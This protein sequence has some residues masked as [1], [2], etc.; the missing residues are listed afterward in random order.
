MMQCFKPILNAVQNGSHPKAPAEG[1]FDPTSVMALFF[2]DQ[3][4]LRLL[5]IQ[6][7]D[8]QGYTWANQMAFPGGH[9]EKTD[10]DSE[11]AALREMEEET[12]ILRKDV[13]VIGSVGHFQTLNNKDI[14][15]WTG[16]WN[17]RGEINHDPNEISR[18]FKIPLSHLIGIHR[19]KQFHFYS[20]D[21]TRLIY[22]YQDVHIW[23]VTAKIVCHIIDLLLKEPNMDLA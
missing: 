16:V 18:I 20:T 1:R 13:Q 3:E 10:P 21:F 11:Q 8:K 15:A 17:G 23:G 12:G 14:E 2:C 22:P 7:A 19:E 9:Q 5:F 6:K 4:T